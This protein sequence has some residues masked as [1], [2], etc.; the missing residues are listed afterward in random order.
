[1]SMVR[2]SVFMERGIYRECKEKANNNDMPLS[3]FLRDIIIK[4]Y[5]SHDIKMEK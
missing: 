2:L 5:R 1:M 3:E 4:N